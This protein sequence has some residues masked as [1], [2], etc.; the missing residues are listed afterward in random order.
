MYGGKQQHFVAMENIMLPAS[1]GMLYVLQYE[2]QFPS[3]QWAN[4]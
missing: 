3:T 2:A 4:P 1:L